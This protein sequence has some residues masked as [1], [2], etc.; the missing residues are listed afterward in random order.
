MRNLV[1]LYLLDNGNL[2]IGSSSKLFVHRTSDQVFY[3]GFR[4]KEVLSVFILKESHPTS[5]HQLSFELKVQAKLA[6]FLQV[7][8]ET[9][10]KCTHQGFKCEI[11]VCLIAFF[12]TRDM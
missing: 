12:T 11:D 5:E 2:Y 3:S 6:S 8:F 4:I 1:Y 10:S 9:I 7:S